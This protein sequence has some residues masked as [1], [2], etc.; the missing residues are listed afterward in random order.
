[1]LAPGPVGV[2][3]STP[4]D[5]SSWSPSGRRPALTNQVYAPS[6]PTAELIANQTIYLEGG[7]AQFYFIGDEGSGISSYQWNFGDNS[8][9]STGA[10]PIHQYNA[11]GN[12]T[13]TL[14]VVDTDG[15]RNVVIEIDYMLVIE[16]TPP[17]AA[18]NANKPSIWEL[19]KTKRKFYLK[20]LKTSKIRILGRKSLILMIESSQ[21]RNM[22]REKKSCG[23][24]LDFIVLRAG[25]S[26]DIF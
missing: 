24:P 21:K 19:K 23:I 13:V 6:P 17:I 26:T 5:G 8:T 9:N 18:F 16:N 22:K 20:I 4:V 11:P 25:S 12:Y 7:Y 15:D 14:T 10:N 1:M 3:L 2:P